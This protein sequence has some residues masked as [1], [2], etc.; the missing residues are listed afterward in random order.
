[1]KKVLLMFI[2]IYFIMSFFSL[3]QADDKSAYFPLQVG[4]IWQYKIDHRNTDFDDRWTT[5]QT[6][7]VLKDTVLAN[8]KTYYY[9]TGF[10]KPYYPA[11]P[12]LVRYDSLSQCLFYAR[13]LF[14]YWPYC[15]ECDEYPLFD[16]NLPDSVY[17]YFYCANYAECE[18]DYK[19]G[20]GQVGNLPD[21]SQYKSF[22]FYDYWTMIKK[23]EYR[24][25]FKNYGISIWKVLNFHQWADAKLIYAKINGQ[26]FGDYYETRVESKPV[27][28]NT[29]FQLD[30]NYPNPFNSSTTIYY[31]INKPGK[32]CLQ[33]YNSAGQVVKTLFDE[34][35]NSGRYSV[36]FNAQNLPSGVYFYQLKSDTRQSLVKEFVYLK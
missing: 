5:Y 32:V 31:T 34:Y 1:M 6:V 27:V 24:I 26:E 36:N 21:S 9:V 12:S 23:R 3:A 11:I 18:A 7:E 29:D 15:N 25:Y 14:S 28:T 33:V 35:R 4:N 30:Q 13:N 8:G 2:A 10:G 22:T 19:T 16:L 20:F 17:H